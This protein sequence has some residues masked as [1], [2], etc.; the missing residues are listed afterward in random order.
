MSQFS[1]LEK[2]VGLQRKG[3]T[4]PPGIEFS[5]LEKLVG[6]QHRLFVND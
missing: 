6:L 2:L 3:R 5:L 4:Y 1:L